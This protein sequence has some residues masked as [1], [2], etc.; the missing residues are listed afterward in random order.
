MVYWLC[1][2]HI[3]GGAFF[4]RLEVENPE[5][6]P[7]VIDLNDGIWGSRLT[8]QVKRELWIKSSRLIQGLMDKNGVQW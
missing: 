3:D 5:E 2:R 6:N 1:H 8:K 4:D 7:C